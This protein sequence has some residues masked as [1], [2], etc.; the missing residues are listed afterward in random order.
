MGIKFTHRDTGCV[1]DV[2]ESLAAKYE[3]RGHK[4]VDAAEKKAATK[5]KPRATKE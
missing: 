2:P 3:Q 1:M 4:R 5:R